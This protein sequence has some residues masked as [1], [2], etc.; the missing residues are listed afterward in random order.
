MV[1]EGLEG[2]AWEIT[3]KVPGKGLDKRE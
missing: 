3:H 1:E 2:K